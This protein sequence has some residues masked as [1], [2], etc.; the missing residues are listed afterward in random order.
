MIE[1]IVTLETAKL[2]KEKGFPNDNSWAFARFYSKG[3][4]GE[5]KITPNSNHIDDCYAPTQ[6]LLQRWLREVHDIYISI[7]WFWKSEYRV[8]IN[9]SGI[10][11][12]E[13]EFNYENHTY[14]EALEK[15]LQEGLRLIK[16][17]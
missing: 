2:A 1:E 17:E 12:H 11:D 16:D 15:G 14:E 10:I 13:D 3:C 9:D 7:E 4:D 8:R 6:S 5:F